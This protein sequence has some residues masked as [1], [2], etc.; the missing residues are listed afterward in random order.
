[1]PVIDAPV[2]HRRQARSDATTHRRIVPTVRFDPR[3]HDRLETYFQ[4]DGGSCPVAVEIST[5]RLRLRHR[6]GDVRRVPVGIAAPAEL[7]AAKTVRR[8]ACGRAPRLVAIRCSRRRSEF[9][10]AENRLALRR[11][12]PANLEPTEAETYGQAEE[13]GVVS[14]LASSG[15]GFAQTSV[16]CYNDYRR[17]PHELSLPSRL[18]RSR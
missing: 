8:R 5:N 4:F 16:R 12:R 15:V 3:Q 1:M 2:L 7:F 9:F 18:E 10:D 6:H 11:K 17:R 13:A 14:T